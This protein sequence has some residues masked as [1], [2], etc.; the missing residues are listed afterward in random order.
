[1]CD[2]TSGG[3]D[4]LVVSSA[5]YRTAINRK[6]LTIRWYCMSRGQIACRLIRQAQILATRGC[7]VQHERQCN[8]KKTKPARRKKN[9]VRDPAGLWA[10]CSL[11][12]WLRIG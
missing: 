8:H 5:L 4:S 10:G 7:V 12:S 3:V 6:K 9:K 1:M 11:F 2:L